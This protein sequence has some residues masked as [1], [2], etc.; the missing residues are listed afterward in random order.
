MTD[1]RFREAV[2]NDHGPLSALL[3]NHEDYRRAMDLE[4]QLLAQLL[5][6]PRK[7]RIFVAERNGD[8]VA[9]L[10][11]KRN[12][13]LCHPATSGLKNIPLRVRLIMT[14]NDIA[15]TSEAVIALRQLVKLSKANLPQ[16]R[17]TGGVHRL[18]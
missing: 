5:A 18:K 7:G 8:I 15:G 17:K 10:H 11:A 1:M 4:P 16:T 2:A 12:A 9:V 6:N 13:F 14:S 3:S